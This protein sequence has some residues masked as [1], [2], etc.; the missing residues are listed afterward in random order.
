[1]GGLGLALRL[2][3]VMLAGTALP[4]QGETASASRGSAWLSWKRGPG[5]RGL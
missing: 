3:A 4:S 5:R 1:M 2:L